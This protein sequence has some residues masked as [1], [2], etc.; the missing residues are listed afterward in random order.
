MSQNQYPET[1][2]R[3]GPEIEHV[4][5]YLRAG[6]Q[7]SEIANALHAKGLGN[8]ELIFIFRAATGASIGDLKS[9]GQWWSELGVTDVPAFDSCAVEVFRKQGA[10]S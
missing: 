5:E 9:L 1:L 3:L 4:K 2:L 7:P 8:I 10:I 6:R